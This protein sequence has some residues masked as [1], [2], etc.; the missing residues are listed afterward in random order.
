MSKGGSSWVVPALGVVLVGLAAVIVVVVT[1]GED[2]EEPDRSPTEERR[3]ER[4]EEREKKAEQL[5]K[6]LSTKPPLRKGPKPPPL[7]R[8]PEPVGDSDGPV[9]LTP[10][11]RLA[12]KSALNGFYSPEALADA[13]RNR[14]AP[15]HAREVNQKYL[16]L[17][18]SKEID[19]GRGIVPV[20]P[21]VEEVVKRL[22][23]VKD[24]VMNMLHTMRPEGQEALQQQ[25]MDRMNDSIGRRIDQLDAD[26]PF[27]GIQK[28]ESL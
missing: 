17:L 18:E 21:E 28:V 6:V 5:K 13:L 24:Y 1:G 27:L 19:Y 22:G 7:V 23:V 14:T 26:Y 2:E 15:D 20:T 11:Q 12:L 9:S 8:D 3:T 16:E 10:E 25:M 4:D